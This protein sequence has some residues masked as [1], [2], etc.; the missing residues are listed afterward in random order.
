MLWIGTYSIA[1]AVLGKLFADHLPYIYQMVKMKVIADNK[2]LETEGDK[3]ESHPFISSL[4]FMSVI[5]IYVLTHNLYLSLFVF[6][7]ACLAY[8]DY[9]MRWVPDLLIYLMVWISFIGSTKPLFEGILSIA[10][11]CIPALVVYLYSYI[12]NKNKCIASGDWYVF[13]SIGLWLS[14]GTAA[15]Y[16]AACIV[17]VAI[18][19]RYT[20]DVPL[21]ACLFPIFV[22]GQLCE[23]YFV[24]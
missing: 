1:M 4:M 9:V 22:G 8:T 20:R 24:F 16:M 21:L 13:P 19:S 5:M 11:F 6:A 15:S 14:P 7:F 23:F 3:N 17:L 12:S 18:I 10:L 2:T